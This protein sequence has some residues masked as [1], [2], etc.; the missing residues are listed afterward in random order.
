MGQTLRVLLATPGDANFAEN[1]RIVDVV[2]EQIVMENF[3]WTRS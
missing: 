3:T 2:S 1:G